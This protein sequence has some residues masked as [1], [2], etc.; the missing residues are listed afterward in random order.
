MKINFSKKP[1]GVSAYVP[2]NVLEKWNPKL[3]IKSE[4]KSEN[5]IEMFDVIG[6][7]YWEDGITASMVTSRLK[8]IG[9]ENPV[10]ILINSGGGDMF[11]GIAIYNLLK[12]HK[13]EVTVKV[14]GLAASAASIIAMAGDVRRIDPSS[15]IM[16]HNAWVRAQGDRNDFIG[17]SEYLAPFDAAMAKVYQDKTGLELDEIVDYMNSETWFNGE[18]AIEKGLA[19]DLMTEEVIEE[20]DNEALAA[21]RQVE[22]TLRNAG[23]SRTKTKALVKELKNSKPSATDEDKPSAIC[24]SDCVALATKLNK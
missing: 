23:F 6:Y 4:V 18:E 1:K 3:K 7:D 21:I 10:T 22:A 17:V 14:V 12:E 24:L 2:A 13:G 5:I 19:T 20:D 11:E 8:E 9:E 16:I 15:F